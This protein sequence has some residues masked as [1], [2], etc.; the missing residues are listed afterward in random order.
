MMMAKNVCNP[1]TGKRE[2]RD[3]KDEEDDAAAPPPF[4]ALYLFTY[5]HYY[6]IIDNNTL[7]YCIYI[8]YVCMYVCMCMYVYTPFSM[9]AMPCVRHLYTYMIH[10]Y[11]YIYE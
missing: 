10:T 8:C 11:I 4:L 5:V 2:E 6:I 1:R 3:R 9:Y 7:T